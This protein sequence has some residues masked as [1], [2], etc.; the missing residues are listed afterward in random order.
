MVIHSSILA[1]EADEPVPV[2]LIKPPSAVSLT[3]VIFNVSRVRVV[4]AF[5]SSKPVYP[6]ILR[7]EVVLPSVAPDT[8]IEPA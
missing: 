1:W 5:E 8:V 6:A 2:I 7:V 4:F 3:L